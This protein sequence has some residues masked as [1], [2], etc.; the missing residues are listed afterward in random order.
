MLRC[1][2]QEW[3]ALVWFV[4]IHVTR[5]SFCVESKWITR[6][7]SSKLDESS[8]RQLCQC[9]WRQSYRQLMILSEYPQYKLHT[10]THKQ[11]L[12]GVEIKLQ[13]TSRLSIL[14]LGPR[15]ACLLSK[16]TTQWTHLLASLATQWPKEAP[17]RVFFSVLSSTCRR[18]ELNLLL[19]FFNKFL[20]LYFFSQQKKRKFRFVDDL[21]VA[22]YLDVAHYNSSSCC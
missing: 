22:A 17:K 3:L 4:W 6:V 14:T 8:E 20:L 1:G 5:S 18:D 12:P 11:L 13:Q 9:W 10:H 16:I 15:W 21:P 19:F 7:S 2:A